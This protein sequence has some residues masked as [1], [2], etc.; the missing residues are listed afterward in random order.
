MAE[1]FDFS[2][3][4]LTPEEITAAGRVGVIRYVASGRPLVSATKAE[5]DGY[6][7]AGLVFV[8]VWQNGPTRALGGQ[9]NG[10]ADGQ[11]AADYTATLGAG[12][13]DPVYF[14]VDANPT[15]DQY[16]A[17]ADYFAAAASVLGWARVGAYVN[18]PTI[19]YLVEHT[20]I[21]L[22]WAHNWGSGGRVPAAANLHQ[23]QINQTVAG[24]AVDYDRSL[25]DY[26]GQW[27]APMVTAPAIRQAPL[28]PQTQPRMSRHDIICVHTMVGYLTSTDA[29]FRTSNG[30]GYDGT[31]SHYGIGGKWGP[32]LGGGWD[33]AIW[34]WQN[35]AY[36]AD[37]NY[38][39]NPRVISIET[40]DNAVRPIEPW[41][42][43][44]VSAITRLVAWLCTPAAHAGCPDT[45]QCHQTGIPAV[46]VPDTQPSRRGLA[47]HAQ[48]AAEHTVGEWWSTTPA[49]DCPTAV[50]I[51]Q[52][53]TTIIPGVRALLAGEPEDDMPY[54]EAQ[55][56]DI[57]RKGVQLELTSPADPSR[58]G[59]REL[60]AMGARD[61]LAASIAAVKADTA[62]SLDDEATLKAAVSDAKTAILAGLAALPVGTVLSDEE[63]ARLAPAIAELLPEV[64]ADK[65]VDLLGARIAGQP[66]P[67]EPTA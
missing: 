54:T 41:T 20:P 51:S 56:V 50:R 27:G 4:R 3:D 67:A 10:V 13:T 59:V 28:G 11:D 62:A 19:D 38:E 5:V 42:A 21:G 16:P 58:T 52:F 26:Y 14:A 44:Q 61:A 9:P 24:K 33:G 40:A 46:L 57:V 49:K 8:A 48:G 15:P 65:I 7:A 25:A 55:L 43:A 23:Y 30:T 1:L 37:A 53:K 34:Q 12:P 18:A 64:A 2:Y 36:T 31:E 17:I 39:G 32:D 60:A 35:L 66:A 45:W 29:Y 22:Y 63:I 47:Y 6:R